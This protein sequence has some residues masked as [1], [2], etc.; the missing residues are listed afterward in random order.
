MP[1]RALAAGVAARIAGRMVAPWLA[2]AAG[3]AALMAALGLAGGACPAQASIGLAGSSTRPTAPLQAF[4][5]SSA[6]DSLIDLE[7]H[8]QSVGVA[9]PT[10][11]DCARSSGRIEGEDTGAIT[12]YARAHRIIVM[13]R[14]NCQD[15]PTV[16]T[17]LTN[18]Y[19]RARTLSGLLRIAESPAYAGL[20]L[21]FENDL[22]TD[23]SAL[24]SFV[25]ALARLLHAHGRR[26]AVDVV[27]VTHDD[28]TIGTGLYDDRT[29]AAAADYV[30]VMAWGTHWAGSVAGPIAPLPFVT[31]VAHYV[32]SLP[33]AD[34]FVLGAP[35]YGL[36]WAMP[37]ASAY[38][39]RA[40]SARA[41]PAPAT[42]LQYANVLALAR[43]TGATPLRDRSVDEV[44]FTYTR[45]G[46]QH[47]VWYM[48]ARAVADRLRIART[49][50][51]GTGV[52]RLGVEE[53][54]L[55]SS[56]TIV[57]GSSAAV[58]RATETGR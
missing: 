39:A 35:M 31:R 41:H 32:A 48:D 12:A 34:R 6:P 19:A 25:I 9:Y 21:D 26:L 43:S 18:R 15:G 24:S 3:V 42:A 33:H 55:W 1:A 10:Y 22:P 11:F 57:E 50:G 14:F 8:P 4:I 44:T 38:P 29:L 51:L 47:R 17:I 53:Q 49:Y 52:W 28:P 7:S 2:G 23:R 54:A 13:P 37:V 46:V 5:L 40:H 27:G 36:D 16:H 56:P 45:A 30:F 58:V 20:N